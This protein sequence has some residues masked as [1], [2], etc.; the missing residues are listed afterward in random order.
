MQPGAA[1]QKPMH[2]EHVKMGDQVV[3]QQQMFGQ[4][5]G[6]VKVHGIEAG[7]YN[8]DVIASLNRMKAAGLTP[9]QIRDG[10]HNL[11]HN[12]PIGPAF[13]SNP[14]AAKEVAGSRGSCSSSSPPAA[15]P[16]SRRASWRG[17]RRPPARPPPPPR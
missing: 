5:P 17:S 4:S 13:A 16:R 12:R 9:A 15:P 2:G 14:A 3:S 7:H 11:L 8:P 6:Q 10:I 1:P